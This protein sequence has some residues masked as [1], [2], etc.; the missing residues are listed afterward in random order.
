MRKALSLRQLKGQ[1]IGDGPLGQVV[2][3]EEPAINYRAI[4]KGNKELARKVLLSL[5][6]K[7]VFLNPMS[8]KLYMSIA[9]DEGIIDNFLDRFDDALAENT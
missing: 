6:R 8:T 7:G 9:H 3:T 2:F 4:N 1:I 5:Y